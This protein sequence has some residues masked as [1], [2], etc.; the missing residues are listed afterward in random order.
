MKDKKVGL[1]NPWSHEI[2]SLYT[3]TEIELWCINHIY[4]TD[5]KEWLTIA[6]RA[7]LKGDG[8]ILGNMIIGS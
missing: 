6:K 5:Q 8:E 3:W 7:F 1:I 2:E 4:V